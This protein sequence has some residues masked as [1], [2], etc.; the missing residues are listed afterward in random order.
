[1]SLIPDL[2]SIAQ[3]QIAGVGKPAV[4]PNKV[5]PASWRGVQF[6]VLSSSGGGTQRLAK[7]RY[8]GKDGGW[9][10]PMGADLGVYRLRGFVLDGDI[11]LG[12]A[13]I[14]M[15][16]SQ[17]L[18]ACL[19]KG[20]GTLAHPTLGNL[21]VVLDR[22]N[23]SEALDASR[24]SEV[25]L[26]FTDAGTQTF[27]TVTTTKSGSASAA[28]KLQTALLSDAVNVIGKLASGQSISALSL[29]GMGTG[30]LGLAGVRADLVATIAGWAGKAI[31]LA[32]D[33]TS[34]L[35]L[36]A[37]LPGNYGRFAAGGNAGLTGINASVYAASTTVDDLISAASTQR[38]AVAE[39][40]SAFEAAA[41][42]TDLANP[43]DLQP[44]ASALMAALVASCADP[45]DAIRLLLQLMAATIDGLQTQ[46]VYVASQL[47]LR[48][49]AA[50][51]C[52]ASANYQPASAN[53]AAARI[54]QICPVLDAL[55]LTASAMGDDDSYNTLAACRG[56]VATDLRTR[57]ATL[58]QV[59][60]FDRAAPLPAL[61]LAQSLYGDPTRADQLVAQA[62]PI[63]PLFFPTSFQAL[64]S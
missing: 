1:M 49:A 44:A 59:T 37:V 63:N 21:T 38:V 32:R 10:E 51:L 25:E 20:S 7:H 41:T 18:K 19:Q 39:A 27:P 55:S 58:A 2:A 15:Q 50:A 61:A 56:T 14:A 36:T 54:A 6:A 53:D 29:L 48:A 5:Q 12:G 43:V 47:V 34:L 40:A 35:R 13:A 62:A 33:A 17:L 45:A 64:A 23:I 28:S 31:V 16:R 22:W 42:N 30:I 60:T 52:Q 24:Y 46:T 57:G 9:P 26:E 3:G 11:K 8:P 4:N